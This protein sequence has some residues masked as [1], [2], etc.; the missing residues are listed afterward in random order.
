MDH[1]TSKRRSNRVDRFLGRL[2]PHVRLDQFLEEFVQKFIV[3]EAAF[4][5]EKVANVCVQ[6]LRGLLEALFEL[7][8]NAHGK[9]F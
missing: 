5:L 1:P 8:E 3:D 2:H 9:L 4:A 6:Q 7:V